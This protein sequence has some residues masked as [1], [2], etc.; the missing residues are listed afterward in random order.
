MYKLWVIHPDGEQYTHEMEKSPSLEWLQKQVGGYIEH[1]T[2]K[3]DGKQVDMIVNE[4]GLLLH[5]PENPIASLVAQRSIVGTAVV[6]VN[7]RVE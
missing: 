6:F 5:L 7:G 2:G 4:E 1:V 3:M